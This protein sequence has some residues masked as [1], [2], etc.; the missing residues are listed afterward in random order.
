MLLGFMYEKR[1]ETLIINMLLWIRLNL[2]FVGMNVR[3]ALFRVLE[4]VPYH[5]TQIRVL[6]WTV[7]SV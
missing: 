6:P 2:V 4:R 7:C 5:R 3:S 1:M